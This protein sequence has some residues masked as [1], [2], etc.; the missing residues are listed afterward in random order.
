MFSDL[1]SGGA[2]LVRLIPRPVM[3]LN[4][5][6][7]LMP[8]AALIA[9]VL[10]FGL[11]NQQIDPID[12]VAVAAVVVGAVLLYPIVKPKKTSVEGQTPSSVL[13]TIQNGGNYTLIAFESDYCASCMTM[14]SRISGL[15]AEPP[16]GLNIMRLIIQ[17]EPGR[18]LFK[19]FDGR[20]TPTY[21]LF[22]KQGKLMEEWVLAL[23]MQRV[24][25]AIRQAQ[26]D[27]QAQPA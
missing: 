16:E 27:T 14:D 18:E 19:K 5:F 17:R 2:R 22:D 8:V 11:N 24:L 15:E 9:L 21:M 13:D 7:Y 25:Y 3:V 10:F 26:G 6:S 12:L 4:Y 20:M 23:P 1:A